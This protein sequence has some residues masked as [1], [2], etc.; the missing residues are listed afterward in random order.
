MRKR[1]YAVTGNNEEH[2]SKIVPLLKKAFPKRL[3]NHGWELHGPPR[4]RDKVLSFDVGYR[5][6]GYRGAQEKSISV[7]FHA[8][9]PYSKEDDAGFVSVSVNGKSDYKNMGLIVYEWNPDRDSD[10]MATEAIG[11]LGEPNL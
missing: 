1:E 5:G 4:Y 9:N 3:N 8:T 2:F 11:I 6:A 7:H 10:S